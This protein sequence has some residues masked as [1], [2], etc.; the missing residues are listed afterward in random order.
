VSASNQWITP[1]SENAVT[2][3]AHEVAEMVRDGWVMARHAIWTAQGGLHLLT[4]GG[5]QMAVLIP[6]PD[7]SLMPAPAPTPTPDPAPIRSPLNTRTAHGLECLAEAFA[8][9]GASRQTIRL[10]LAIAEAAAQMRL[11]ESVMDQLPRETQEMLRER[12]GL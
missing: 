5:E 11:Y 3:S 10:A 2:K 1:T 7:D 12:R 8:S 4:R 9:V 6:E